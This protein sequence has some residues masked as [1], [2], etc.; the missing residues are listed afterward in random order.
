MEAKKLL[1]IGM[2]ISTGVFGAT[3]EVVKTTSNITIDRSYEQLEAEFKA[4]EQKE[5]EKFMQE[6]KIAM[7]AEKSL[8]ILNNLNMKIAERE[9]QLAL[10]ENS[11]IYTEEVKRLFK[12]YQTLST[13]IDKQQKLEARKVFEFNQL[14]S[15]R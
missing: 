12:E 9:K 11:S 13:S 4:L 7:A 6:E 2:L 1:V 3:K 8:G 15:L 5:N 14:K 10:M